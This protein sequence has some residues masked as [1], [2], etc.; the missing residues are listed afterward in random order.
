MPSPR[1][2]PPPSP[3]REK[4]GKVS[5]GALLVLGA[6][7]L[8]STGGVG[9]KTLD[10]P[11]LKIAF[12]RSAFAATALFLILRPRVRRWSPAFL[13][14]LVTYAACLVSFVVA[15]KWTTAAN[16]IFLQYAGVIWVL[17]L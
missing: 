5:R 1:R 16:A 7:L 15:T 14:A 2:N 8:W 6:A 4:T 3:A 11:P 12:Y 10:E 13:A 9:I 17:L